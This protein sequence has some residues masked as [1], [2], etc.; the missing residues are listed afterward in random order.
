M[1]KT[2]KSTTDSQNCNHGLNLRSFRTTHPLTVE[3]TEAQNIKVICIRTHSMVLCVSTK[4]RIHNF[5]NF[6][7]NSPPSLELYTISSSLLSPYCVLGARRRAF[8]ALSHFALPWTWEADAVGGPTFYKRNKHSA[9]SHTRKQHCWD[10]NSY[11]GTRA[12]EPLTILTP[13]YPQTAPSTTP[14]LPAKYAT[15][16]GDAAQ[17]P[18]GTLLLLLIQKEALTCPSLPTPALE[19]GTI[20][21][22]PHQSPDKWLV[23]HRA[24]SHLTF[25]LT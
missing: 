22:D 14:T 19:A 11:C 18:D 25:P 23:T 16:M 8:C 9:R 10:Q 4:G 6:M 1:L 7:S 21:G 20:A 13:C 24:K 17:F 2:K 15:H 3:E 5:P 12:S